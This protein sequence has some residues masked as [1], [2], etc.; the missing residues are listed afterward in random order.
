MAVPVDS[1]GMIG[2][3]EAGDRADVITTQDAGAGSLTA[4]S[5]AARNSLVLAVLDGDGT[6]RRRARQVTIRVPDDAAAAIAAAAD[7]G[8][9]WLVLRPP[10]GAR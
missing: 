10:V 4:A 5:V 1:A 9:V 6:A 8:E 3:I 2:K 7:G